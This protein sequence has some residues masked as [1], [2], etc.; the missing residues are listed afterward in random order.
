MSICPQ[1]LDG[2]QQ[3]L[4]TESK[5]KCEAL[6]MKKKL[7]TDVLDLDTALEHA[8]AA[9]AETQKQIKKYQQSL[10]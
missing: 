7:E 1:A 9:N 5:G 6:R 3:A 8:N 2:M 10:R 4:E